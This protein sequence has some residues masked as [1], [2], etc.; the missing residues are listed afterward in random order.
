MLLWNLFPLAY[1][2]TGVF[3]VLAVSGIGSRSG[4]ALI[5][6]YLVPPLLTR[7]W[8]LVLGRPE[9]EVDETQA[10]F[11][12][13]WALSQFQ[14]VFSR[15]PLL[16]EVLRLV[17]GLYNFWLRLWGARVSLSVYWSPG[18]QVFDRY[19][20]NIGPGVIIGGNARVGAHLVERRG[21]GRFH[22]HVAPLTIEAGATLGM[23]AAAGPGVHVAANAIVP[24]G[25]VLRPGQ[26][27]PPGEDPER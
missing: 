1:I 24:I 26:Q 7:L 5:W 6:I 12:H 23:N 20:L 25:R 21:D 14:L 16:E 10:A 27:W 9:G 22:L 15:F 11:R 13:W 3:A 2:V 18:V 19:H 17:P 4:A 8:I